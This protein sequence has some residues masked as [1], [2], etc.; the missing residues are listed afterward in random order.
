MEFWQL[1]PVDGSAALTVEAS[2]DPWSP[3]WAEV[4][5]H[6]VGEISELFLDAK[7]RTALAKAANPGHG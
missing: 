2:S 5:L 4:L 6:R 1:R 7:G 3:D